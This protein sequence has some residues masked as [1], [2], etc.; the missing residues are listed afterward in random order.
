MKTIK[1]GETDY[2]LTETAEELSIKRYT[3]LEALMVFKMTGVQIPSLVEAM[4]GFIAGFDENSKSKMLISLKD[5]HT[6]LLEI[7]NKNNSDQLIYS[8]IVLEENEDSTEYNSGLAKEKLDRMNKDGLTQKVVRE[9]VDAFI[10]AS[11]LL[12]AQS[13]LMSLEGQKMKQE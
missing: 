12:Y 7:Q 11:P 13:L 1:I 3:E 5:Y 8:L 6:G 2:F 10:V 9:T 4:R